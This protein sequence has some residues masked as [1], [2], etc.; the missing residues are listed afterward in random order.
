MKRLSISE[1]RA[2]WAGRGALS[3]D[4]ADYARIE[5]SAAAVA[6]ALKSG[7]AI[8]GVNT[9]FGKL[10]NTRIEAA[11]LEELQRNLVLSHA[12]GVGADLPARV[13]RLALAIKIVTLAQGRS[14]VRRVVIDALLRLL[15]A[16]ALPV[17]PSQGSVGA[18]GD[19]APLAHLSCALIGEGEIALGGERLPAR[20]ALKRIGLEPLALGPK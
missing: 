7:A 2:I 20:A 3:L 10:A 1:L 6:E 11:K 14:G 4:A 12:V 9:G 13:V 16:D 8:Y 15:E 5:A 19:L 17:I 18:S